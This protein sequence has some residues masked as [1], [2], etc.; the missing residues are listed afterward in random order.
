MWKWTTFAAALLLLAVA[1]S[2]FYGVN[3]EARLWDSRTRGE[4]CSSKY[5]I[6]VRVRNFTYRRLA[7][8]MIDME[9]WLDER[10][11]DHLADKRPRLF[12]AVI[13]PFSSRTLCFT[14]P[15]FDNS[16]DAPLPDDG[17]RM[18]QMLRE[19]RHRREQ[20]DSL[21]DRVTFSVQTYLEDFR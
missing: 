1:L 14:D 5:P 9:M 10:A 2:G 7:S 4:H 8:V 6:E 16:G 15:I 20:L 18:G 11:T 3:A 21:R 12:D 17:F 19:S 13:P